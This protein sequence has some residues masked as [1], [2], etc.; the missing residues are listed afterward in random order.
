MWHRFMQGWAGATLFSFLLLFVA[1]GVFSTLSLQS[2]TA[3]AAEEGAAAEGGEA[4]A[5]AEPTGPKTQSFL[6]WLYRSLGLKYVIVFLIISFNLVALIVMNSMA[7]RRDSVVPPALVQG[8]E[9]HLNEK[10]YQEAY[11]MAKNDESFLGKVLAAGM[12][13]LSEGYDKTVEAMQ[14][15]GEEENM[16]LDQRL[17]YVSLI[18]QIGPMFGLLG[19]VDGM[20]QAFDVIA[21]SSTTP[22]PSEL[23]VGIGTALVTTV[24]GLWIAIPSIIFYHFI[25]NRFTKLVAEAGAV[26]T[27][28]MK[29]FETVG[30]KKA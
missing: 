15:A 30:T 21:S 12:A 13:K 3:V 6:A 7:A 1:L 24:V 9:A 19:T 23:A 29:R 27:E 17:S 8:F 14:E 10:R 26:S 22:K 5:D 28:L 25:K 4:A 20:V 18:G 11:E 2:T 16:R